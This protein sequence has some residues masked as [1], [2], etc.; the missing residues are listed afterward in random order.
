MKF[1]FNF[2]V[3]KKILLK[4]LKRAFKK[5]GFARIFSS[6]S[7]FILVADLIIPKKNNF[8]VFPV[9]FLNENLVCN[10]RAVFEEV[11]NDSGIKKIILTRSK[12]VNV[13][14]SNVEIFPLKSWVGLW[15]LLRSKVVFVRHGVDSNVEYNL[16]YQRRNFINL[17]HGIPLKR[18]G[19]ASAKD[20]KR[21][22]E[23]IYRHYHK[24]CSMVIS[25]SDIDRLA[26]AAAM[27]PTLFGEVYVTG[28]PRNDFILC[29]EPNLPQDFKKELEEIRVLKGDK[30]LILYAPTFR[31]KQQES[32]YKFHSDEIEK[33]GSFL[34]KNDAILGI[35]EHMFDKSH[36]FS[37]QLSQLQPLDMNKY[38]NIEMIFRQADVLITD[39]SSCFVDFMLTNKAIVNFAYDYDRYMNEER[40]FFYDMNMV[41]PNRVNK[42][43]NEFIENLENS[44][45]KEAD[46]H[47]N[48]CKKIFF[49]F[50]DYS[51]SKRVVEIIRNKLKK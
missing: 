46:A 10:T 25:S 23:R 36:S 6:R 24:R 5:S 27:S 16:S 51:S 40:G 8:W 22:N 45:Q 47:Y 41:F 42:N 32:Y 44:W 48:N 31:D 30:K 11:K 14:G 39:Y 34:K 1:V 17:W 35:R 13:D 12:A 9:C 49:K 43:F 4:E 21:A 29:P 18:I 15:F 2:S 7:L 38:K 33:L 37:K 50:C 20:V 26:M 19:A 3:I 28:L